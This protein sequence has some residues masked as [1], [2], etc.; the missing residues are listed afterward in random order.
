MEKLK[1]IYSR[2]KHGIPLIAYLVVYLVWF[3]WLEKTNTKNFWVIH[4]DADDYIPF[5]EIF[6]IPYLLWFVYV[7]AVV[8]YLLLKDKQEY[9]KACLFLCTGMTLF[10]IISTLW[11][12]GHNLRPAIMPRDNVFTALI[13][14]LWKTDTPTN[15][16]PSIHVFN[17][18]GAHFAITHS[19]KLMDSKWGKP[20]R[21]GSATLAVSIILSTMLI[22]QHSVFDVMTGL[23]LGAVMYA[24]VYKREWLLAGKTQEN[25]KKRTPQV[26]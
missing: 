21:I 2:Y 18:M 17:S 11:P 7:A 5:C 19:K 24:V 12:N 10:L 22:K 9:Y 3:G 6:V 8:I 1:N 4:L 26:D 16:W 25:K 23:A 14:I 15:L 13:A 20:V